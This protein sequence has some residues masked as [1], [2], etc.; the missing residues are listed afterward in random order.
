M[1]SAFPPVNR[2]GAPWAGSYVQPPPTQSQSGGLYPSLPSA[3]QAPRAIAGH[4]GLSGPPGPPGPHGA[5]QQRLSSI[6]TIRVPDLKKQIKPLELGADFIDSYLEKDRKYPELD[7]IIMQ[8]QSSEYCYLEN[9]EDM[10]ALVPFTRTST[11]NIPDAIFDQYNETVSFTRMGLFPEISRAWIT[12]DNKLFFWNFLN[13]SDF[14]TFEDIQQ[15]II[16]VNLVKPRPGTFVESVKYLLVLS[17]PLEV[18]LLAVSYSNDELQLYDTGMVVSV[19]GLDVSHVIGDDKSGRIFFTGDADG[20]NIWEIVYSNVETWFRGKCSKVCHTRSGLSALVP[21]LSIP[22]LSSA[23]TSSEDGSGGLSGIPLLSSL[24]PGA[25]S[26]TI[27][28]TVIDET[29]SLLYTLSSR[30]TIRAYFITGKQELNHSVTYNLSQML[31]HLQMIMATANNNVQGGQVNNAQQPTVDKK[32]KIVSIHV[33]KKYESNQI[34]LVAI[35]STGCRLYLR[36]ARSLM[37]GGFS[38][39]EN[40]P[41][42]TMQVVQVRFPPAEN[43]TVAPSQSKLLNNTKSTSRIFEPGHFFAVVPSD[44]GDRVLASSIDAGRIV[45]QQSSTSLSAPPAYIE[46]ATFLQMEGFV[47]AIELIS[48]PFRPSQTPEGFGNECAA[49]YSLPPPQVAILT[50]TSVYVFTRVFPNE[51]FVNLGQDVRT[52][53]EFYGRTESCAAALGVASK[54]S[55][56]TPQERELAT[57]VYIDVG[58]KPHL[59]VDDENTYS[60]IVSAVGVSAKEGSDIVRLSGRFD[61]LAT[62]IARNIRDFWDIR[63]FKTNK[64]TSGA[65]PTKDQVGDFTFALNVPKST[66]DRALVALFEVSE[67]LEKNR[68]FI[69]GLS[70][71]PDSYLTTSSRA[72]ELSLQAEHRGLDSLVKLIKSIREGIAFILLLLEETEHSSNGI[73]AI[74]AYLDKPTREKISQ[75]TFKNFFTTSEGTE[76]AKELVTCLVNR[77]IA[78]GESVESIARVLQDRSESYCSPNDVITYKALEQLRRAR[79]AGNADLPLKT[80]SLLESVRL[81]EQAATTTSIDTLK[82]A[83]NEYIALDYYPGAVQVAL[84]IASAV[85]RGNL[86]LAYLHAGKPAGDSRA[87]IYDNRVE[88]YKLIFDV[89]DRVDKL[90]EDERT[91]KGVDGGADQQLQYGSL[92]DETYTI[93]FNCK[94]EVF[95]F[96]FYDWF[97]QKGLDQRLLYVTTPFILPYLQARA[98][99]DFHVANLLWQYYSKHDD[100]YST[101]EVLFELARSEFDVSLSQRIEFLSRGK[102]FCNSACAPNLMQ[103]M[104]RLAE[105]IQEYMDIALVQ[106][107]ILNRVWNDARFT[108]EKRQEAVKVLDGKILNVSD[109]FNEFADPLEYFEVCLNIFRVTDF[110]GSDEIMRCWKKLI[111]STHEKAASE[112]GGEGA[113]Y[114]YISQVVQRLGQQFMLAEFVFPVSFLLSQLEAYSYEYAANAPRGWVVDTFLNAG[115]NYDALYGLLND[116][117]QRREFPFDD[118]DAMVKLASDI[119]YL[120]DKWASTS[121]SRVVKDYVS[122]DQYQQLKALAPREMT[123]NITKLFEL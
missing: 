45:H 27:T 48:P 1:D 35:T 107:E 61:G 71:G 18:Y 39:A 44:Q 70:S 49:Q 4:Q 81:F 87:G 92:R 62:Y 32:M 105:A 42:T 111:T 65:K 86:A 67:F 101:A 96:S 82:E 36:A 19:K 30:S 120:I 56:A 64:T 108:E 16:S 122:P 5:S 83:I 55:A 9:S 123:S 106:D 26:E 77:S 117:L 54:V 95:H 66:L 53:L 28:S 10:G 8:G 85:D 46:N 7:R 12:V 80:Q 119:I 3:T 11:I 113:G 93:S 112:G 97:L 33:V 15:T 34:H 116:L 90:A 38:G 43:A 72:D 17:T 74:M 13:G 29:R 21:S 79:V 63:V 52:F 89:L 91:E 22:G 102:G 99:E 37:F 59:K 100:Y 75:L 88:I 60:S 20:T 121:R 50:N 40:Q 78:D 31:S 41:P 115:V 114:E 84:S 73:E 51:M 69:D 2:N 68:A 14:L 98:K 94:D 118:H 104:N 24:V 25:Q 58:G 76:L 103:S 23:S 57:S 110:Q 47:Q 6:G 109:L